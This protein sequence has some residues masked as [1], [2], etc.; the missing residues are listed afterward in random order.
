MNKFVFTFF[1]LMATVA[2]I[3]LGADAKA[4]GEIYNKTCKG[5]HGAD[6]AAPNEQLA[7]M[8]NVTIPTL[9]SP[10]FQAA[11]SDDD[12]RNAITKGKGKMPAQKSVPAASV[13]DVVAYIRSL[14]K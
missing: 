14:K 3:A 4:G 13:D 1:A 8:M 6:G 11:K 7:K 10:E 2:G 9:A 12:I 5:C